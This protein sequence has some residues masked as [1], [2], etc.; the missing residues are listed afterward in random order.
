MKGKELEYGENLL[1]TLIRA[2]STNLR[3]IK[4]FDNIKFSLETLETFFENWRG[5][6]A[7]SIFTH[8][9]HYKEDDYIKL[10]NKYKND[11]VIKVFNK[12]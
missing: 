6:P 11:D 2:A 4:I 12:L 8:Q 9:W 10:I 5:R 7:I 3:E 1:N